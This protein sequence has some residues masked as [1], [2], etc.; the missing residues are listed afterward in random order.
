MSEHFVYWVIKVKESKK[1]EYA[2][3]ALRKNVIGIGWSGVILPSYK[4]GLLSYK[5]LYTTL[6]KAYGGKTQQ[7]KPAAA[8]AAPPSRSP[9]LPAQ[10]WRRM[11]RRR[12]RS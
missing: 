10:R 9:P 11:R 8:P 1:E 7:A 12:S 3:E 2:Q 5:N 4:D 6:E